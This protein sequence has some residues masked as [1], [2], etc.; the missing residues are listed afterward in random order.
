MD[1]LHVGMAAPKKQHERNATIVK[2]FA[3][4]LGPFIFHKSKNQTKMIQ[5]SK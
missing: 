5:K 3:T 1:L 2:I 4:R